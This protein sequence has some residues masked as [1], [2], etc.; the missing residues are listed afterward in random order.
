[1][2]LKPFIAEKGLM[3]QLLGSAA[4]LAMAA[5]LVDGSRDAT[6][7]TDDNRIGFYWDRTPAAEKIGFVVMGTESFSITADGITLPVGAGAGKV[8]TSNVDGNATWEDASGITEAPIDG[9]LYAR[10]N[11]DWSSFNP[12][13]EEAPVDAT[14]YVRQDAGWVSITPF[15]D[16]PS[17]GLFYGRQYE[18]WAAVV[19]EAPIDGF[20]YARQ[21]GTWVNIN[22]TFLTDA[23]SDGSP[24]ARKDGAWYAFAEGQ[25]P[26]GDSGS[27]QYNGGG[28]EGNSDLLWD[29][30][31]N[32]LSIFNVFFGIGLHGTISEGN[33]LIGEGCNLFGTN[34]LGIGRYVLQVDNLDGDSNHVIGAHAGAAMG[35]CNDNTVFGAFGAAGL[36][37][38]SENTVIGADTVLLAATSKC[39]LLGYGTSAGTFTEST[40]LGHGSVIDRDYQIRLG[41]ATTTAV[42]LTDGCYFYLRGREDVDGSVRIFSDASNVSK[43]E[44]RTSG[45]WAHLDWDGSGSIGGT[46]AANQVAYG[47]GTDEIQG[48]AALTFDGTA[49]SVGTASTTTG[50][51][52]LL[53]AG[54]AFELALQAGAT[55]ASY[56]LTLPTSAALALSAVYA[57]AGSSLANDGTGTCLWVDGH[58]AHGFDIIDSTAR[59]AQSTLAFDPATGTFTIAPVSGTF[60]I[61]KNG[62]A[63]NLGSKSVVIPNTAGTPTTP[64]LYYISF[65]A[66]NNLVAGTGSWSIYTGSL[67][68]TIYYLSPTLYAINDERHNAT[69]NRAWHLWAHTTIG[70]RYE[71]GLVGTFTNTTLSL[72]S[73]ILHDEDIRFD[74]ASTRTNCRLWRYD[75]TRM[76]FT[77]V[78]TPYLVNAGTLQYDLNG[79]ATNL[80]NNNYVIND[81]Y[82]TTDPLRPIYIRV[83][84]TQYTTS[85]NATAALG[86]TSPWPGLA[87]AEL[88]LLYQVIYRN[89]GGT[90]TFI[91]AR[92]YRVATSVPGGGTLAYVGGSGTVNTLAKWTAGN[93][94]GDSSVL[95]DGTMVTISRTLDLAPV[96]GTAALNLA[97]DT[98]DPASPV[99]GDVW[100]RGATINALRF[101][102]GSASVQVSAQIQKRTIRLRGQVM[103]SVV[104]GAQSINIASQ[105][106][107]TIV[108]W[109]IITDVATTASLDVW[110]LNGANPTVANTIVA[111]APPTIT[112][113]TYA[114]STTLTGWTTAV[115]VGDVFELNVGSNSAAK[116]ITLELDITVD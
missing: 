84:T 44:S 99:A 42:N 73:G 85:G 37:T 112:A 76:V 9:A 96:S 61:W 39:T 100:Y 113:A 52:K 45:T 57:N 94:I 33:L 77:E 109:R 28:F 79:V 38:G 27:I 68:A 31:Y 106:T 10:Q 34:N 30:T 25:Y 83:G 86:T 60:R 93:T 47:S 59:N 95:D 32:S 2:A 97:P 105:V 75:G 40:A 88:K 92:D 74:T 87:L 51:F 1:M 89:Q 70:T 58:Y 35:T 72:T 71:S 48:S 14:P 66:S 43:L 17:D 26:G 80:T 55:T 20:T 8:L 63:Y 36:T 23:P 46:I 56:T 108:G 98:V 22:S 50:L 54:S 62:V 13:V 103:A 82:G 21:D 115:A 116:V 90:P 67:V 12:G 64:G 7:L 91:Q 114:A 110:K 107:G 69:R 11:G 3:T 49:L 18:G 19:G 15:V 111:S 102:N 78:T 5:P 53:N 81:V 16:A 101:Y 29:A 6:C 65:D 24:Y 4:A 41:S 104:S